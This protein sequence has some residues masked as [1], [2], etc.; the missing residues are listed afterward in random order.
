MTIEETKNKFFL[1]S[2]RIQAS[3]ILGLGAVQAL[4]GS[5][6]IDLPVWLTTEWLTNLLST[7]TGDSGLGSALLDA[8]G[9]GAIVWSY[10]RPDGATLTALPAKTHAPVGDAGAQ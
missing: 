9:A 4:A 5:A 7:I 6:G 8:Y 1:R 2:R 10:L 3:L